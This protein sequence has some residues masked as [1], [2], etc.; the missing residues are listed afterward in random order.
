MDRYDKLTTLATDNIV[1][2]TV[3]TK[4]TP[5]AKYSLIVD[6]SDRQTDRQTDRRI[7]SSLKP[8]SHHVG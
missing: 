5:S 2:S 7:S 8:R 1:T 4:V 6:D 3:T